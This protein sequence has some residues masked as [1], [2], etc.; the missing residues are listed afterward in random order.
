MI[1]NVISFFKSRQAQL[2]SDMAVVYS[3]L[4]SASEHRHAYAKSWIAFGETAALMIKSQ[5]PELEEKYAQLKCLFAEVGEIHEEL[6]KCERR[7][8]EDFRDVIERFYVL[9]RTNE[10]YLDLKHEYKEACNAY[11]N[12]KD[13]FDEESAKPGFEARRAKYET[14]LQKA[15]GEKH[16]RLIEFKKKVA[17]VLHVKSGYNTFKVKRM[18]HAFTVYGQGIETAAERE[19]DVYE[20]IKVLLSELTLDDAAQAAVAAQLSEPAPTPVPPEQVASSVPDAPA[21]ENDN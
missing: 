8:A 3:G 11:L 5:V 4:L 17:H 15:K 14:R 13:A 16:V 7:C 20:R 6:A 10:E 12:A 2:S 1:D 9:Y 18:K 19:A 21:D